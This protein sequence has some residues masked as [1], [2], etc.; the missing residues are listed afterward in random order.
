MCVPIYYQIGM[1]L[2]KIYNTIRTCSVAMIRTRPDPK[3]FTDLDPD[4][5]LK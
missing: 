2:C 5:V 1:P 3:L 4:P